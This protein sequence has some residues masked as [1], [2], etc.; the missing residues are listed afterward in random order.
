[1]RY[2]LVNVLVLLVFSSLE[3]QQNHK[4]QK[5]VKIRPLGRGCLQSQLELH[6]VPEIRL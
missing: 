2:S 3:Y 5:W 6:I 4:T 1:M